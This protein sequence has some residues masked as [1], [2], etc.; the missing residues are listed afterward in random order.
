[1]KLEPH[2]FLRVAGGRDFLLW[3]GAD[4][5]SLI[6]EK[7]HAD[8]FCAHMATEIARAAQVSLGRRFRL[9]LA[10]ADD[11]DGARA[12][13]S[14]LVTRPAVSCRF[15]PSSWTLA[16]LQF[17]ADRGND[18]ARQALSARMA[19]SRRALM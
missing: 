18:G 1:M 19:L 10:T 5:F 3:D 16:D 4:G 15:E 14:D 17:A 2:Y 11:Q 7:R 9:V 6:H 13:V 8:V 12:N